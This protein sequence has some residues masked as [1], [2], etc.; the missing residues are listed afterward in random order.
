MTTTDPDQ[1]RQEIEQT[2]AELSSDVN[3]L[4]D[5][6]SPRRVVGARVERARGAFRGAQERIM[7][8]ASDVS[9]A[10]SS[11]AS[12]AGETATAAPRMLRE[13][14]EGSPL[15]AGLVAFG[16]GVVISSMLPRTEREQQL[17]QQ[18]KEKV[19]E[20]ADTLKE[21]AA[22]IG[23]DAKENLREPAQQAVEAVKS[24]ASEAAGTVKDEG[25]TAARD[26]QGQARQA[27]ENV[28]NR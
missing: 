4:T 23:Q 8:T 13:K 21:K 7:G 26:V 1:I 3:A 10:A 15:A 11:A 27:K 19:G 14:A 2:R 25:R 17:A 6:V 20:H 18:V 5:K 28:T 24:T 22:E 12:S 16:I 9:S